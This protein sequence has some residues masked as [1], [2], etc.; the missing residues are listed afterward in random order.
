MN[1]RKPLYLFYA[2]LRGYRFPSLLSAYLRDY[3]RGVN[4]ETAKDALR[5]LLQH[6]RTAVPYYAELLEQVGVD[7]IQGDPR[8]CLR[9]LPIL[10][11]ETIRANFSRLQSN[12][13]P[14]R[15]SYTNTSGGSTGEPIRLVQDAEYRDGRAALALFY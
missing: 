3:K 10:R 1:W 7:D 15:R 11:K 8:E 4:G 5:Q 9:H 2:S 6:C 13:L 12:D 14:S